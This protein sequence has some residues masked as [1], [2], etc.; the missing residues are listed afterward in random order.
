MSMYCLTLEDGTPLKQ[1]VESGRTTEPDPDLAADMYLAAQEAMRREGYRH[2]EISNW[3]QAGFEGRHNITYWR[4]RPYLGVGPGGPLVY[5]VSPFLQPALAE[6]VHRAAPR[7]PGAGP[8]RHPGTQPRGHKGR[9]GR[10]GR[11]DCRPPT[12]DGRDADAGLRLDEGIGVA[13]FKARFGVAPAEA[14]G[15]EIGEAASLELLDITEDRLRLT[16]RGRMF[17]NEVFRRFFDR[18]GGLR[19]GRSV[20]YNG[21]RTYVLIIFSEQYEEKFGSR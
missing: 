4:N 15:D 9:A 12:G 13:E 17:S 7:R 5:R 8:N 14:Y 11:G 19:T 20:W 16:H 21:N 6:G 1:A 10:R 2:Y 18:R 3:A